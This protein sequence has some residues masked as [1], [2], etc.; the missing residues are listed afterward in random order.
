MESTYVKFRRCGNSPR[1]WLP[2]RLDCS[3]GQPENSCLPNYRLTTPA[4][5]RR[6]NPAPTQPK[7]SSIRICLSSACAT[8][9]H[10]GLRQATQTAIPFVLRNYR[11]TYGLPG[12]K[13]RLVI[14]HIGTKKKPPA[15]INWPGGIHESTK[16]S[17]KRLWLDVS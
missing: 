3:C 16:S 5:L 1:R 4:L 6:H 12:G 9:S 2:W 7:P 11:K 17:V 8:A 14:R 10:R 13:L 15:Q